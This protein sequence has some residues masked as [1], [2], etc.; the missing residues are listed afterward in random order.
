MTK[1][2][3]KSHSPYPYPGLPH[4]SAFVLWRVILEIKAGCVI[5]KGAILIFKL[6]NINFRKDKWKDK[7]NVS[8][9]SRKS[10]QMSIYNEILKYV[11]SN[12]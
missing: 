5:F 12:T 7:T 10:E 2:C 3:P 1:A 11:N 8:C 4:V 9:L 6:I